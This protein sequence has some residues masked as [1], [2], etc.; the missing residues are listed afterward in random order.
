[1]S[2]ASDDKISITTTAAEVLRVGRE[3]GSAK[4]TLDKILRIL[5]EVGEESH[6]LSESFKIDLKGII[7]LAILAH[8]DILEARQKWL[9]IAESIEL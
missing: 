8:S 6:S 1:M 9:A 7:D 5:Y 3:I 4:R 2:L